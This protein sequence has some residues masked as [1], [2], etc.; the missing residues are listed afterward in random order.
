MQFYASPEVEFC[1]YVMSLYEIK[2][3]P[4]APRP[5]V[6]FRNLSSDAY[7]IYE[8]CK[9]TLFNDALSRTNT[10]KHEAPLC[11]REWVLIVII[12]IMGPEGVLGV[13]RATLFNDALSRISKPKHEDL[14]AHATGV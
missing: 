6:E 1:L 9:A 2:S 5:Q 3:A 7:T 8:K 4:P 13:R 12:F 10:P 11:A 14:Y